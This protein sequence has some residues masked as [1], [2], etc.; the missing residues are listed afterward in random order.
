MNAD[1]LVCPGCDGLNNYAPTAWTNPAGLTFDTAVDIL[2]V[3]YYGV[4]HDGTRNCGSDVRRTLA[5]D[6]KNLYQS[7]ASCTNAT[8]AAATIAANGVHTGGLRHMWRRDDGS[9]TTD[10]FN[11]LIGGATNQFCNACPTGATCTFPAAQGTDF[12]D[13]DAIRVR[14]NGNGRTTG[15]QVCGNAATPANLGNLGLVTVVFVPRNQDVPAA[16]TYPAGIC[17]T[18]QKLLPSTSPVFVGKCPGNNPAFG[19]K[20]F[21][22]VISPAATPQGFNAN[23]V[24][25][26]APAGACPALT[27]R[28]H[29]VP[30]RQPLAPQTGR[31]D[32]EGLLVPAGRG[33]G[34]ALSPAPSTRSTPRPSRPTAPVPAPRRAHPPS[35]SVAS[36]ARLTRAARALRATAP[37]IHP[38][39]PSPWR[40]RA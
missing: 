1:G 19:G 8:C 10:V 20:C 34:S 14:C 24:Q 3:L 7:P 13:N 33:R 29:R 4:H 38:A 39:T 5:R 28:Q 21:A 17:G 12:L 27:P 23:C 40:S 25:Y 36:S 9:G 11:T 16:D 30:W 18:S 31:R 15:D 2:R 26:Q 32:P 35:R 6:I 22:S 37:W